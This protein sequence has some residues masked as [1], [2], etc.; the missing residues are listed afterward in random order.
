MLRCFY[1]AYFNA[2]GLGVLVGDGSLTSYGLEHILET[3]YSYA[4]TPSTKV[5][6]H[7]QFV[8]NPAYNTLRGPVNAL[9][10]RLHIRILRFANGCEI[11][12]PLRRARIQR[13]I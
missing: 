8:A 1:Q 3:Y 5:S 4:I 2:G 12:P 9:A 10:A 13:K 6:V 11:W 7:Y